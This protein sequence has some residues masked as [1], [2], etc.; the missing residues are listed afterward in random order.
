VN[1][2]LCNILATALEF[3]TVSSKIVQ[4]VNAIKTDTQTSNSSSYVDITG[5]SA[6]ITPTSASNKVL[7]FC[8]LSLTAQHGN[9][10]GARILR[11]STAIGIAD[12]TG[13]SRR[14]SFSG[15]GYTGDG[16]G[17]AQ[18]Q[19]ALTT[20]YLDSPATTSATTYKVQVV[21]EGTNYW[22]VNVPVDSGGSAPGT[23]SDTV[24]SVSTITLMEVQV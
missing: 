3:G 19:F 1:R 10:G 20:S 6:S 7:V 5:L 14:S 21:S 23:T 24:K 15:N 9:G 13:S 8:N 17:E 16:A 22:G 11:D 12:A 2:I 4:V 18:M